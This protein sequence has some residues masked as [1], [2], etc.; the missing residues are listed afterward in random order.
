MLIVNFIEKHKR[1]IQIILLILIGLI[2]VPFLIL[3]IEH[4]LNFGWF[5]DADNGDWLGFWGGYLGAIVSVFGV[6]WSVNEQFKHEKKVQADQEL[7]NTLPY[8]N[9]SG[10]K[11]TSNSNTQEDYKTIF[12]TENDKLPIMQLTVQFFDKK[13]HLLK[14]Q[15]DSDNVGKEGDDHLGLGYKFPNKSFCLKSYKFMTKSDRKPDRCDIFA[16]LTNG[17]TIFFT[18]GNGVNGAHF[19][20]KNGEGPWIPYVTENTK[21]C[22]DEALRRANET[23]MKYV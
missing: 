15:K 3:V 22:R 5:L 19:Y 11:T 16:K 13:N 7:K 21:K 1:V 8:F 17:N 14:L 6:Y 10:I 20:K 23:N 2:F 9:M 4:I 12:S 18:Y